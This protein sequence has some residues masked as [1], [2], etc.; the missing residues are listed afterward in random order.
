MREGL[1]EANPVIATNDPAAGTKPRDRVLSDSELK[2]IWAACDDSDDFGR[3]VRLLILT[4]ARRQEIGGL[5]WDEIDFETGMLALPAT[6]TKNHRAH[7][8]A[9]PAAAL[10]ILRSTPHRRDYVFGDVGPGFTSWSNATEALKR[11]ISAPLPPWRLHDIRRSTATHMAEI[12][13]APHIVE[14]ILNHVSGHK[15]GIAGIYNKATYAEQ[16]RIALAKWA[17]HVEALITGKRP[18]TV[19]KLPKRRTAS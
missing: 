6:R 8:L 16:T 18:S 12:G 10:E 13:V 9:L 15:G 19:V 4:G 1:C 7:E 14:A 5:K 11:G 17:D 3:I 2:T